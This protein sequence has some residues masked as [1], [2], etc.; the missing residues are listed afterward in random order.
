MAG[1][2]SERPSPREMDMLLSTGER[3]SCALC[4]MAI[5][6]L[7]Y[8]AIAGALAGSPHMP[9]TQTADVVGAWSAAAAVL[10]ALLQRHRTGRG[11]W[12]DQALLD[13]AGHAAVTAWAAESA[14][15]REVGEPLMLTGAIPCYA[16]YRTRDDGWLALAA[17]EPRFW[18]RLCRALGRKDLIFKQYARDAGVRRQVAALVAERTRAEWALFM[19][20]HDVPAEPVLSLSE[21]LAHPQV[22]HRELVR[23]GDDQLPR[24]G[25]PALVDGERPRGGEHFPELG[26]H[27]EAVLD[28]LG[29]APE[30]IDALRASGAI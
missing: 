2:I 15:P 3:I 23:P 29:Y 4:A 7:G 11:A 17:L 28:E 19:A 16:L 8:Q 25:Y 30:E 6:D 20:E 24:L 14:G 22:R 21:A 1:E 12:I 26:E 9:A 5:W 18:Q 10:G 13:A 27:T